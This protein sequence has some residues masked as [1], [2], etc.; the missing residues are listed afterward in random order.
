SAP[1]GV[2]LTEQ[3]PIAWQMRNGSRAAVTVGY[4]LEADGTIGF[5]VLANRYD[6]TLPLVIDPS[7]VYSMYLGGSGNDQGSAIAVDSGNNVYVVGLTVGNFRGGSN[8]PTTGGAYQTFV[9]GSYDAF[10]TKLNASGSALVYSTYLGGSGLEKANAIAVDASGNA[11]VAGYTYSPDFP[12]TTGAF[13]TTNGGGNCSV[14][15]CGDAFL[16]KLNPTGTGLIYSTYLG[17][18]GFDEASG[19]GFDLGGGAYVAGLTMS[20]NFPTT[21]GAAQKTFGGGADDAFVAKFNANGSALIYSTYLGG[22]GNDAANAIAVDGL[23]G[24]VYVTGLTSGSFPIIGAYQSTYGGGTNDAF[25]T[26]LNPAGSAFVYSTYLGGG[27][28]DSGNA[29]VE[30]SSGD[31]YLAGETVSPNFPVTAGA[32]QI[33]F[34]GGTNGFVTKLNAAGSGATYSTYLGGNSDTQATDLAIDSSGNAYVTGLTSGALPITSQASQIAL[35]GGGS[36]GFVVR[37]NTAGSA[38]TYSTYLGGSGLDFAWGIALDTSNNVYVVGQTSGSFPVTGGS[39]QTAY[40][41]FSTDAFVSKLTLP[42]Q[43]DLLRIDSIG[44]FRPSTNSFYLRLH[45]STGF[46]DITVDYNPASRPYPVAG[47]WTGSSFDTI[48]IFDQSNGLF[49]LRNSN[50]PGNPDIQL[51][52]GN[53]NDTPLA[54]R[55]TPGAA[56]SGAGVFRPSNGLIYLKNNL[57]T[58]FADYTMVLGIPGDNGVAGDWTGDGMDSPG[59]YRPSTITYYLSNQVCNC[60]VFGDY[61]FQYGATGDA[62]VIGDWIGQGHAGVGLFRQSNGYTYL[63]NG[64]ATGFADIPFT[65]GNAGDVPLAGHWQIVYPPM[66]PPENVLVVPTIAPVPTRSAPLSGLG[67]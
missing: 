22:T 16:T 47:D 18:T 43:P 54:G 48:G 5:A 30:D 2:T 6:S 38:L 52:L 51:V 36:D 13:Q 28:N 23:T 65:Y 33:T 15:N 4:Q 46:A 10:V 37:L 1:G 11:Y 53:P 24:N 7:L 14:Y 32:F 21:S 50:T 34:G 44:I 25:V 31:V 64:L 56:H 58:G 39:F 35:G 26:K 57:T 20:S 59:V 17:G 49:S 40:G 55:W 12:T 60:A 63:K 27:G 45:N 67:D 42:A 66:P 19:V 3:A 8:F 41:G 61:G 29:I 9:N 62:P